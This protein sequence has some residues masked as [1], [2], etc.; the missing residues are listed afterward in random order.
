MKERGKR[1][2]EKLRFVYGEEIGGRTAERLGRL[3]EGWRGKLPGVP[4]PKGGGVPAD[5]G[6]AVMITYGDN[7][8]SP[9]E[10]PLGVLKR[11]ADERLSGVVSGIH[12]LPF[13]PYS[14][15]DG[16]SVMDYRRVN[17]EW[18]DWEDISAIAGNFRFM[19]DLVLNHCSAKG[20][21]FQGYLRGEGE[22]A[23]YFIEVEPGTDLSGVFR[24]RALPLTHE[25]SVGGGAGGTGGEKRQIWTTF[26]ADQVDLNFAN[27]DVFLEFADI[28]LDYV[29]RGVRIIRLDAVGFLW[30]EIGTSCMHHPKT[31][32]I[33]KLFRLVLG[34]LAPGVILI[35]ETNV[36]H[37]DNISYFGSGKD[38]AHM[39][40][41]FTLP[42]L[43]LDAFIRGDASKLTRWA[44][45][46]PEPNPDCTFFNFLASHDGVGVL[47]SRGYL[48]E[49]E[50][51][52]LVTAVKERGGLVSYKSTPEGDIPYELNVSYLDAVSEM[53]LSDELR[54]RKF[55][56]SQGVMLAM[57]G[58]PGIYIHSLLGSGNWSVG[59][60][61][62]G[63]NRTIN[64]AKLNAD[65]LVL[66]L[67]DSRSLRHLIFHGY[68]RMLR[69]RKGHPAFHPAAGQE[70]LDLGSGVFAAVRGGRAGEAAGAGTGEG[71]A[72]AGGG[73]AG[74]G[75]GG[76]GPG[77]A[78]PAH[79]GR[80]PVLA[81]HSVI[82]ESQ[83]VRLG[84]PW[85]SAGPFRDLISGREV[86]ERFS[87][88]AWEVLWLE[89]AG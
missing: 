21:W 46:L 39:V 17:P 83:D 14:S 62:T 25:F 40:Y 36:P 35:T 86:P 88:E 16:F 45:G 23:D 37:K 26:S 78:V 82:G 58:V 64:R 55:L 49:S 1:I 41:Q 66:E 4:G 72:G 70:I 13:S 65:D 11:F 2:D 27:P 71:G 3:M 51:E 31:H 50:L 57:A 18:G 44:M 54:A 7:I 53:S 84:E 38:E 24:P 19:A 32:E 60:G 9:G 73:G 61:I 22:F 28:L 69:A 48:D 81:L 80:P 67:D 85:A 34:E 42:P 5:Q 43:T 59:V 89:A 29:K 6:D 10:A 74:A 33:I 79:R 75:G 87:L 56:A 63:V 52:N 30:K 76:A 47:P 8:Q 77:E 20:T 12:V 15:D 68:A